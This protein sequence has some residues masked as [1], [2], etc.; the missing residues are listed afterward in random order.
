MLSTCYSSSPSDP[1]NPPLH[2][3]LHSSSSPFFQFQILKLPPH[4]IPPPLHCPSISVA[5]HPS[6]SPRSSR[7]RLI[8]SL[9]TLRSGK[10]LPPNSTTDCSYSPRRQ[11]SS[12][13]SNCSS[14]KKISSPKMTMTFHKIENSKT[15]LAI[16][17][18]IL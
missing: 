14:L 13:C 16:A 4:R 5:S 18:P 11:P 17:L 8:F 3:N 10:Y 2:H 12:P 15:P 6:A 1:S 9:C 7:L